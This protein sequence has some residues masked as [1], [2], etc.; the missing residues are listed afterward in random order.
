LPFAIEETEMKT[1]SQFML[2]AA[3][4]GAASLMFLT[5][6]SGH[7]EEVKASGKGIA[8]GALL[9]AEIV[10]I[11]EALAG[12]DK[13]AVYA[14]SAGLGAI[15]GGV[16]GYFIEDADPTSDGKVPMYMLAG[17]LALIIPSVVLYL[18]ATRYKPS[19]DA[20]EDRAPVNVTP[21][22][23][24]KIGGSVVIGTE[25]AKP[26]PAPPQPQTPPTP[27]NPAPQGPQ[28]LF[29]LQK[30]QLRLGVPVPV[31]KPMWSLQEQ[32]QYGASQGTE[33]R[34]PVLKMVF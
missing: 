15:A 27:P 23:P 11:I 2:K 31:V 28:S 25:P 12:V 20:T 7:A 8:G 18:N 9:G 33:V 21:A 4:L 22:D 30:G 6:T 19:E 16:G 3:S 13:P 34:V 14:I 26:N 32:R 10:T 1:R 29:D 17:G 24:G 5:A